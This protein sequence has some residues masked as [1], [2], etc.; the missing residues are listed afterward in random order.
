MFGNREVCIGLSVAVEI[1]PLVQIMQLVAHFVK[2]FTGRVDTLSPALY[3]SPRR[4]DQPC[5]TRSDRCVEREA[6]SAL[7]RLLLTA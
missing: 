4:D 3:S 1:I 2:R 7:R 6:R 5:S